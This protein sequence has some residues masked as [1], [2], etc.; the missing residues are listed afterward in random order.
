M[1]PVTDWNIEYE[2]EIEHAISARMDG[3]EGM[4]RV[5]ARRAA[6][7]IIGEY[8]IRRGYTNLSNSV[9]ERMSIFLS[10]PDVDGHYR[11]IANHFLLK[12]NTNHKLPIDAD[13]INDAQWL[14][15]N[16]LS[17]NTD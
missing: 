6:S 7:I 13:L 4:A 9:F 15:N 14:V 2:N 12:V 10:L 1:N 17:E 5:C 3:N 11:D 8:L 16:L